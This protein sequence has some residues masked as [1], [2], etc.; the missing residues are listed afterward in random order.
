V[1]R[2]RSSLVT[3]ESP[4]CPAP[5]RCPP[6]LPNATA[7]RSRPGPPRVG[8]GRAG[9]DAP[10]RVGNGSEPISGKVVVIDPGH[11]GGNAGHARDIATQVDIDNG[12]KEC[13]TVWAGPARPRHPT[14]TQ[15]ITS[16]GPAQVAGAISP[17]PPN[18]ALKCLA[19]NSKD[20]GRNLAT[21]L[22]K[23][24]PKVAT[25]DL[26]KLAGRVGGHLWQVWA[27]GLV[28]GVATWFANQK[29]DGCLDAQRVS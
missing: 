16:F 4:G 15:C 8:T 20:V 23:A 1:R 18:P 11:D 24:F 2:G 26:G 29:L 22:A 10:R 5:A 6:A 19:S 25:E 12:S 21:I 14:A 9:A 7:A 3:G 17:P 13:D 27:A 28:F